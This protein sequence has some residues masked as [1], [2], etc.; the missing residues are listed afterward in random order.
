MHRHSTI[1]TILRRNA[2]KPAFPALSHN[3][4]RGTVAFVD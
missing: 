3:P 2:A 1:A 4:H